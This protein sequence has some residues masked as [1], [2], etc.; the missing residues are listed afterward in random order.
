VHSAQVATQRK[1]RPLLDAIR[2]VY[3][4][5]S[6][7]PS[8]TL[9]GYPGARALLEE[10]YS[11]EGTEPP[12]PEDALNYL[13]DAAIDR[14][15]YSARD[16]FGAVFNYMDMTQRHRDAFELNYEDLRDTVSALS[17]NRRAKHSISHRILALS[18]VDQ[19]PLTRVSWNVD[20]KS[21][22]VSRNHIPGTG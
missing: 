12:S 20:I 5:P 22:W 18:P 10:R 1:Y 7:N 15:G 9:A 3:G 13:L 14:F 4:S 6:P 21:D 2:E 17:N 19:G 16:V 8:D 11:E